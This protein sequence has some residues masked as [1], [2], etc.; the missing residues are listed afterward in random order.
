MGVTEELQGVMRDASAALG[1]EGQAHPAEAMAAYG[2]C[3]GRLNYIMDVLVEPQQQDLAVVC[4]G[5]LGML[6]T[7]QHRAQVIRCT[8]EAAPHSDRSLWLHRLLCGCICRGFK[9]HSS[10]V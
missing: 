6:Q 2:R 7:C 3:M 4:R 9:H 8:C 5:M 10:N 1:L